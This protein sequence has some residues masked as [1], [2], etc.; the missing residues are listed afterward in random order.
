PD[1]RKFDVEGYRIYRGRT[2][3]DLALVAQF[4][5][6]G[7]QIVDY[8]G[9]FAYTTDIGNGPLPS[10]TFPDGKVACAPELGVQ[11]DCPD[12][13]PT[14]AVTPRAAGPNVSQTAVVAGVYGADGFKLDPTAQ[15]PDIDT[16]TGTFKGNMPPANDGALV[17][18]S[19]V[20]EA[21]PLGDI[22]VTIDSVSAG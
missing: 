4:D 13:D 9:T 14:T 22:S 17:L 11:D 7:T 5:Y 21:L 8:T 12:T 1:F 10:D 3:G 16:L 20:V 6:S 2:T 18:G 15:F 19:A